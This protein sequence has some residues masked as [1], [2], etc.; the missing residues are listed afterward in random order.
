M[1]LPQNDVF[2]GRSFPYYF[3][4]LKQQP[5]ARPDGF[6]AKNRDAL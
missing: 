4:E 2:D 5:N 1:G 6:A 3:V